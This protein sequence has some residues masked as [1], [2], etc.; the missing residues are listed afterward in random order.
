MV[1]NRIRKVAGFPANSEFA[2]ASVVAKALPNGDYQVTKNRYGRCGRMT[3]KDFDGAAEI[4]LDENDL[5]LV[6]EDPNG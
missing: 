6:W 4:A 2:E 1:D 5:V 3:A